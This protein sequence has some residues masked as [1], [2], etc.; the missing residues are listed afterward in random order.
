MWSRS[1]DTGYARPG[2][3]P[4]H[5]LLLQTSRPRPQTAVSSLDAPSTPSAEPSEQGKKQEHEHQQSEE[6]HH[7]YG[8][9]HGRQL[10]YPR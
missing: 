1:P 7:V 10:L 2:D 4:V 3:G 6:Q 5:R 8:E 9:N